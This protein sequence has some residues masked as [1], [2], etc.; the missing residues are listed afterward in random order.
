VDSADIPFAPKGEEIIPLVVPDTSSAKPFHFKAREAAAAKGLSC[1]GT[2]KNGDPCGWIVS[3]PGGYC[4]IHDPAI[5]E[6]QRKASRS[7]RHFPKLTGKRTTK[8]KEDV[9]ALVSARLDQW[10]AQWSTALTPETE[11][12]FCQLVNTYCNVYKCT[13]DEAA[14]GIAH[15]SLKRRQA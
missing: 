8:T 13:S 1:I 14:L 7:K 9:L 10:I 3:K 2:K 15:W 12:T 5:T 11:A 4:Y 6:E